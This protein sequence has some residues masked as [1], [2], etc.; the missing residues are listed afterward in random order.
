[1]TARPDKAGAGLRGTKPNASGAVDAIGRVH[2]LARPDARI[3]SLVPSITELLFELGAGD[4]LVGRTGFCVH[5]R[6]RIRTVPKVGGTKSVDVERIRELAPTHLIV[7]IDENEKPTVDR[8]AAFVPNVIVTHPLGPLDNLE[9][10]RM[11]GRIFGREER[12]GELCE[13]FRKAYS[14]ALDACAKLPRERV[15]YLI[16]KSPWMTVSRDTYISRTLAAV[17]WD[18]VETDAKER[19]PTIALTP[20]LLGNVERVLLSSEPYAFRECHLDEIRRIPA[21]AGSFFIPTPVEE[22]DSQVNVSLIDGE[23]TSWYG[24]RAIAGMKYLARLRTG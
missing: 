16:W 22:P 12:A 24:S 21:A 10:Y 7:N 6:G 11:L 2:A 23:M 5:P 3:V 15:L 9:L 20:Q 14:D 1:M 18:T 17:G 8:L 4:R 19:Y 13:A